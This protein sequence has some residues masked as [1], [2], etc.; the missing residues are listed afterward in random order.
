MCGGGGGGA[1]YDPTYQQ[2]I[3]NQTKANELNFARDRDAQAANAKRAAD[4]A[5]ATKLTEATSNAPTLVSKY[6]AD[7]GITP[8]QD[9][10]SRITQSILG[11]VPTGDPNPAQ[12]FNSDAIAGEVGKIEQANRQ[13]YNA[14]LNQSFAPGFERSLIPDTADDAIVNSILGEQRATANKALDFNKARGLLNDTGYNTATG[15]LGTQEAAGRSTLQ[16]LSDSVLGKYRQ[17]LSDIRGEA[18]T[19][20]SNY[21]FGQPAPDFSGYV[22]RAQTKAGEDLAGIEG[23]V[24]GALGSTNLFD[25]PTA[26]QKGG[27]MQGPI[28]LTTAAAPGGVPVP[29]AERRTPTGR[30]VGS[31]GIF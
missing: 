1:S 9:T 15:N 3:D 13:G 18:G 5:A 12:Y 17:G 16:S 21:S 20:A 26:L 10:L 27:T 11:T 30:G 8:D 29:G 25:V 23:S 2:N 28:N 6:F 4:E 7:R 22:T 14:K 19:L 24:R 31:S